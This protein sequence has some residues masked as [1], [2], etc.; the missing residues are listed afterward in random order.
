MPSP[1]RSP[2]PASR[3]ALRLG[4]RRPGPRPRVRQ[5]RAPARRRRGRSA[6]RD[7]HLRAAAARRSAAGCPPRW[8]SYLLDIQPG[9]EQRPR[10]R[11]LQPR[12]DHRR[13]AGDL[14]RRPVADRLAA[15]DRAGE[16]ACFLQTA[17]HER[18]R[19]S[20]PPRGPRRHRGGRAPAHGRLDA[21]LRAPAAQPHRQP[22]PR[23]A[24]GPSRADRGRAR[25]RSASRSSGTRARPAPTR[26]RPT[27]STR[28]RRC[29]TS[30]SDA[31]DGR[32]ARRRWS[33]LLAL[34]DPE[35]RPADPARASAAGYLDLLGAT[36]P[37]S[38]GAAQ[39][40]MLTGIVPA[41]Y[42]RWWRPALGRVAK[43]V[44][45]P[46]MADEHRIARLLLGPV[47]G[48]RR[49]RRGLRARQ[50]HP[51]VR[52]RGRARRGWPSASTPP[53]RC[54]PARCR[55]RP[56]PDSNIAYIRGNA[57][58]LPFRDAAF[59]AVC[60]FAALH[61][62]GEPF[63]ALDHMARVLTS[64]GRIA[65][66]TSCRTSSSP[67]R[68][69][70]ALLGARQRDADVRA[71]RD[72][73]RARR[74][75]LHG[76]HPAGGG[77]DAVRGRPEARSRAA[78]ARRPNGI[79]E[80]GPGASS[81]ESIDE[82]M[83]YRPPNVPHRCDGN[84]RTRPPRCRRSGRR[85]PSGSSRRRD[86]TSACRCGRAASLRRRPR[87]SRARARCAGSRARRPTRRAAARPYPCSPGPAGGA[88]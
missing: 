8:S 46:R 80:G 45:G 43:G 70:D 7:G 4:R 61:L 15:R 6:L 35:E 14:G 60:C 10:P 57:I 47:A 85:R 64:G 12:L 21:A 49:P 65:I 32:P 29:S 72:H 52:A 2:S 31:Q 56:I 67:L 66:F 82:L 41:I 53:P 75:R 78:A 22:D 3:R 59:D 69:V 88:R 50:L 42:E 18:S 1:T 26:T 73:R 48:R 34:L 38:T 25:D 13:R 27:T 17:S 68:T 37:A 33:V 20:S 77:P 84:G 81:G 16:R 28:C 30:A 63:T 58:E 36:Q 9:Y 87:A 40:L 86:P 76:R 55:T 24:G 62:F 5:R 51:R 71:R 44:L 11:R 74:A 54:S 39:E 19:G 79:I 23:P 83:G